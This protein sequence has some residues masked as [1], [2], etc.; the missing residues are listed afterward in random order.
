[1]LLVRGLE[2]ARRRVL[3]NELSYR[4]RGRGKRPYFYA[5][6]KDR[7]TQSL[8]AEYHRLLVAEGMV[9]L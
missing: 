2:V 1:V 4:D 7:S 8:R 3:R 5:A 6:F 9:W